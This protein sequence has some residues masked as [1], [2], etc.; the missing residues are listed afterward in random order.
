MA[1]VMGK[2][3]TNVGRFAPNMHGQGYYSAENAGITTEEQ[4]GIER[5]AQTD[6]TTV[7]AS[8]ETLIPYPN[9]T[10]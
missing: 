1:P 2:T 5:A 8:T 4:H 10:A 7:V 3:K 6:W 9:Q